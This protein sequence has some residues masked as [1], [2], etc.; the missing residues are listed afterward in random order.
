MRVL[1]SAVPIHPAA[2]DLVHAKEPLMPLPSFLGPFTPIAPPAAHSFGPLG[3]AGAATLAFSMQAQSQTQWCQVATG[4]LGA[5][6]CAAP[7]SGPCNKPWYL[8]AALTWVGHLAQPCIGT[9]IALGTG[10]PGTVSIEDEINGG[11]P[12]GCHISWSGGGG[13]FNAIYGYDTAT[14]DVDVADPHY[15]IVTLPYTVFQTKYQG[16][17]SWDASY[18]TH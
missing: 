9:S 3:G 1:P 16:T 15:S 2:P 13:H 7:S 4:V 11:R 8:D 5:G 10:G 6:C 18:L 12:V 14:G 17:G